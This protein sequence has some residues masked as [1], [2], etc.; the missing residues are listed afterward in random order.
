MPAN[1]YGNTC[2]HTLFDVGCTLSAAAFQQASSVVAPA[3]SYNSQNININ[4]SPAAGLTYALGRIVM[5]SGLNSGL[6]QRILG[7]NGVNQIQLAAP[8]P[9]T[10]NVGDQF[11]IYPGCDKSMTTCTAFNNLVNYGGYPFIPVPELGFVFAITVGSVIAKMC[12][13]AWQGLG[14]FI[15]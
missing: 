4:V 1:L 7:W 5:T 6:Q 14:S 11:L 12:W 9:F 10:V 2:R 13:A 15:C 3:P 8:F